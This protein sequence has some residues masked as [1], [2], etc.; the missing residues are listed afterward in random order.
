MQ[1]D[2]KLK[3][4]ALI[5]SALFRLL[6]SCA[7]RSKSYFQ[8]STCTPTSREMAGRWRDLHPYIAMA[9]AGPGSLAEEDGEEEVLNEVYGWARMYDEVR[10]ICFLSLCVCLSL[11]ALWV[12]LTQCPSL[13]LYP[14]P[15]TSS[16]YLSLS[17][18]LSL[19]L[20]F[21][22]I[23]LINHL[24]HTQ[25]VSVSVNDHRSPRRRTRR[26]LPPTKMKRKKK[27][28]RKRKRRRKMRREFGRRRATVHS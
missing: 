8:L 20:H 11:S 2:T 7:S 13:S 15:S 5:E 12:S 25:P 4:P 3:D 28:M 14:S 24:A 9:S 27:S 6:E 22:A 1:V 26:E 18:H 10:S 17:L 21:S 23:Y 16:R 19:C